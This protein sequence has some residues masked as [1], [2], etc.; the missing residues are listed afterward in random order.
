[1]NQGFRDGSGLRYGSGG[2][3]GRLGDTLTASRLRALGLGIA[4]VH[5]ARG[6]RRPL[7][8]GHDGRF[9]GPAL[10]DLLDR[11]LSASG[12]PVLRVE[13]PVATPVVT[14]SLAR[15]A[16]GGGL[17]L[18]ASHNE[19]ADH[20]LKVF[21]ED[22]CGIDRD[23]AQAIERAA[24]APRAKRSGR[25]RVRRPLKLV[26]GYIRALAELLDSA[27]G[28]RAT[29]RNGAPPRV[30]YD[31]LHGCGASALSSLLT[32]RGVNLVLRRALCDPRFGASLPN[33]EPNQV[34]ALCRE[35][36][37]T[38][39]AIGVAT[40]G[41]GD[42]FAA[43]DESGERI[44]EPECTALLIDFL[45]REY[46]VHGAVALSMAAGRCAAD[47]AAFHS[48]PVTVHPVGFRYIAAELRGGRALLGGDES[49]GFAWGAFG[50]DKDGILACALMIE[51][52]RRAGGL[53]AARK[54]L[55]RSVPIPKWGKRA[56]PADTR[57]LSRLRDL[58]LRPPREVAGV[59]VVE[60]SSRGGFWLGFADGFLML[61]ASETEGVVRCYAEAPT[62]EVLERRM[63]AADRLLSPP[64]KP[65][66]RDR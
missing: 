36:A 22:G 40:D 66:S 56:R 64:A 43:I 5:R 52:A 12:H 48:L 14:H 4:R 42:R 7:L 2:W 45:V 60:V 37:A 29:P 6:E 55:A 20:G 18:T 62:R 17:V 11:T 26:A 35:V 58:A 59:R 63:S 27:K 23:F 33:P 34:E 13:S 9:L 32:E 25:Q 53:R 28:A 65:R 44:P 3:R 46:S 8:L 47:T 49:G 50:N 61:R 30:I 31:A 39:G 10:A 38:R 15:G 54:R 24:S 51:L 21:D 16:Y 19:A 41:D 1:M 57:V